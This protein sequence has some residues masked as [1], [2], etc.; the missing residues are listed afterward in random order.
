MEVINLKK[1]III[2]VIVLAVIAAFFLGT[3][4]SSKENKVIP[5]NTTF[6]ETKEKTN[7]STTVDTSTAKMSDTE[8]YEKAVE[9][10]KNEAIKNEDHIN[11]KPGYHK[12]ATYEGFGVAEENGTT[13]AYMWI[14]DTSYYKENGEIVSGSG[15]SMAYKVKFENNEVVSYENP[16]DGAGNQA[17][18]MKMFPKDVAEK[19]NKYNVDWDK[20]ENEVKEYYNSNP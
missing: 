1:V 16:T 20:F 2:V 18:I 5:T 17:D 8:Y 11:T 4:M 3:K 7:S 10:V 9:Y 14:A 13:Y 12:F 19:I 15:S 6:T